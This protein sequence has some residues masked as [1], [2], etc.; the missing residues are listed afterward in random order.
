[1]LERGLPRGWRN[2]RRW[3][4]QMG[5]SGVKIGT[6]TT[7]WTRGTRGTRG[8]TVTRGNGATRG[9]GAGRWEVVARGDVTQQPARQKAQERHAER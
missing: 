7:S 1:M 2:K 6:V 5:G 9:T 8:N 3:H 4:R